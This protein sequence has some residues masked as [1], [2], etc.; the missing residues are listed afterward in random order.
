MSE[1][2]DFFGWFDLFSFRLN[3]FVDEFVGGWQ[4]W[5]FIFDG[6]RWSENNWDEGI[7][8]SKKYKKIKWI[9]V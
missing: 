2:E 4:E 3:Y 8:Y 5:W 7:A 9:I 6:D 1:N